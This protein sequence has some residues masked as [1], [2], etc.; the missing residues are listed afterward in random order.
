M[1]SLDRDDLHAVDSLHGASTQGN[2]LSARRVFA[3][4]NF[5]FRAHRIIDTDLSLSNPMEES[6]IGG[7]G[8]KRKVFE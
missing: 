7:I 8:F 1:V 6:V 4:L 5:S 2:G 3:F